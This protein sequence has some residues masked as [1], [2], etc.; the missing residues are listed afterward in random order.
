MSIG[1]KVAEKKTGRHNWLLSFKTVGAVHW[2]ASLDYI[3][4]A[5]CIHRSANG[6]MQNNVY[7]ESMLPLLCKNINQVTFL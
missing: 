3:I 7:A 1:E 6:T 4:G 5:F 2:S